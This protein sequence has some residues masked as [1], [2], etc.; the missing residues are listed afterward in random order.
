MISSKM[1]LRD[2]LESWK[3]PP[4]PDTADKVVLRI[5]SAQPP[6]G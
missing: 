1:V 6:S 2:V 3:H 4:R 5:F